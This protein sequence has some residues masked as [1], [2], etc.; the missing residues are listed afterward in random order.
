MSPPI[1]CCRVIS[2]KTTRLLPTV[3]IDGAGSFQDGGV[4]PRNNNPIWLGLSEVRRLWPKTPVPD[5][6]I[7]LGTGSPAAPHSP[8]APSFRNVLLDGFLARGY[9][10]IDSSYDGD[11]SWMELQNVLAQKSYVR[12][13]APLGRRPATSSDM[14][15]FARHVERQLA[16]AAEI[17]QASKLLLLSNFF[18]Q[19]DAK[20]EFQR[21]F[22]HCVGSIR[23]REQ[24][25]IVLRVLSSFCPDRIDIYKDKVNLGL[26]LAEENICG[27]CG[28]YHQPIRFFVR[29]LEDNIALAFQCEG[30]PYNLS[31]FPTTMQWFI[32]EQG[33]DNSFGSTNHGVPFRMRC[34]MCE[35][36]KGIREG[37]KRK[38][39]DI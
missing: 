12:I 25:R 27:S 24:A 16:E 17:R 18:F 26:C 32:D 15:R 14:D 22:F 10:F 36:G 7:S 23:C 28:R 13:N 1:P 38:Y 39:I 19:L 31:Q 11:E 30:V 5:V 29:H 21:G 6:V 2:D 4:K 34:K 33:L 35:E 9:R 20:P 37:K 3:N 8:K